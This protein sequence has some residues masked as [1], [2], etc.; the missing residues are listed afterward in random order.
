VSRRAGFTLIEVLVSIVLTSVIA[1]LVYGVAQVARDTQARS[2]EA[3]GSLQRTLTLRLLIESA[4]AGAQSSFLAP[5]SA[6][7]LESRVGPGGGPQDRLTFVASGDIAP[8]SPGADWIVRLE[9]TP[10]GL[11]VRGKPMGTR[12]PDRILGEAPGVTGLAIR[13]QDA[14]FGVAWSD[15][16]DFP[17]ALPDA[18]ELTYWTQTGPIGVPIRVTLALGDGQ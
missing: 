15:H 16:W 18:V 7:V 3:W 8:L 12:L 10:N 2:D 11:R 13:V 9:P 5:D 14:S 1:L 6:F 4:L 17:A